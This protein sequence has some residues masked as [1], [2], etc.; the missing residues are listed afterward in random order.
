MSLAWLLAKR[1]WIVPIPGTTNAR[2]LD[3]DL[4]ALAVRFTPAELTEFDAELVKVVV[5]G[6]RLRD[7]LFELS[8][9][10]AP[11]KARS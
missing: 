2:H 4:G 3:E 8:C 6:Q 7:G 5:H 10:E 1:P 11:P 9:V